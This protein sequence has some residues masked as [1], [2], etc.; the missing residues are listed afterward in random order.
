MQR[1]STYLLGEQDFTSF[2]AS[3]CESKSPMRCVHKLDVYRKGDFI[4]LTIQ[5]NAF[6]H[7][8]VRN[9][10]GTLMAVGEGEYEPE[11]VQEV[12]KAKD[13]RQASKTAPANGL[14]LASVTYPAQYLFPQAGHFLI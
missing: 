6:L 4:V 11:W 5:A 14:Y 7:H 10:D 12:L 3:Q 1:A 13:R 9:I 8:M 2:R